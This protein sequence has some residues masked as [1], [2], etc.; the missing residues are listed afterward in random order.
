[1]RRLIVLI[2]GLVLLATA[3]PAGAQE[4]GLEDPIPEVIEPG[5][6]HLTLDSVTA[7]LV[8]PVWGTAAPGHDDHLW[9]ADQAGTLWSINT[10]TGARTLV[11][12]LSDRLVD[13]G[14]FG[15]GT[16]DE[17]GFLGVAFSPDYAENGLL[18]T[19]TSEPD[20]AEPDFSTM[21]LGTTPNH[22]TVVAEWRVVDPSD[23]TSSVDP[24]T[25]REILRIDQPQFNH[26]AG[27][28]VFGPDDMLYIALGDGGGA[29][30]QG[31]GHSPQGNGQDLSN[32]LGAV[33]RIDPSGSDSANGQYGIPDDNP[34]VGEEGVVEEIYAYGF[35][36]PYRMSFDG[37]TLWLA[38]VG[39]N[40]I[41]EVDI[42]IAGGNYGWRLKEGSFLFDPN[43]SDPGFVTG[44]GSVPGVD[45]I[46][47]IAEYDHDEGVAVIGGFVYRGDAIPQLHGRY[48]F[49]ESLEPGTGVGR[50]FYLAPND[51]IA[52]F[53]LPNRDDLGAR[54]L[55]FG[56]GADGEIYAL[57]NAQ[58]L[59]F[60]TTGAVQRLEPFRGPNR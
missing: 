9:V 2:A 23:P 22:Q 5:G 11:A 13:L 54:L 37:S 29:D 45:L 52:E 12:D 40:D 28:L 56:Q 47:P 17:R 53:R 7:G 38:D 10:E 42:V 39:Q 3:L 25:R 14:A 31:V 1:M 51:R 57:T 33:L 26:N 19:Y 30:D 20:S 4:A 16:F 24:A 34:F 15:P 60:G 46:D 44:Q 32:P 48:V 58:G 50:L 18:Y 43:G 41:E 49:G 6:V 35:R 55:G 36:N 21:P 59:P 27:V 8:A